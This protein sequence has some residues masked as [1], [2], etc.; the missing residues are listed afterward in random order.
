MVSD[1]NSI[2]PWMM[3][4]EILRWIEVDLVLG[5]ERR[6][7]WKSCFGDFVSYRL[8]LDWIKAALNIVLTC[9]LVL[10]QIFQFF[11]DAPTC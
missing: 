4:F 2:G 1:Q 8:F 11:S 5:E 9:A 3:C 10:F 6:G 7:G